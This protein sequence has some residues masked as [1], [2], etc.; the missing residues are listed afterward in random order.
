MAVEIFSSPIS[1]SF[2]WAI[3]RSNLVVYPIDEILTMKGP[4]L[5]V[6]IENLPSISET[7]PDE[8]LESLGFNNATAIPGK[9]SEVD[10]SLMVPL[11]FTCAIETIGKNKQITNQRVFLK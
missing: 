2:P 3:I 8:M 6:S 4:F 5:L 7:A 1:I 9:D 11:T 10:L